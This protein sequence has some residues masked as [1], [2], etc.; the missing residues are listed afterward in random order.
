MKDDFT[1]LIGFANQDT[2]ELFEAV[3]MDTKILSDFLAYFKKMARH[4]NDLTSAFDNYLNSIENDPCAVYS[5]GKLPSEDLIPPLL[6]EQFA[7]VQKLILACA[8][9]SNQ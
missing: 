2:A 1:E 8:K 9:F 4:S 7:L 3:S 5:D 6:A